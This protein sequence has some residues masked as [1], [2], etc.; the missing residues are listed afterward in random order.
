MTGDGNGMEWN[1]MEMAWNGNGMEWNGIPCVFL[2]RTLGRQLH[3]D[4]NSKALEIFTAILHSKLVVCWKHWTMTTTSVE[5]R[6]L[7]SP[8]ES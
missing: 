5:T 7:Y 2:A 6:Q 1:G 8:L 4:G 3:V